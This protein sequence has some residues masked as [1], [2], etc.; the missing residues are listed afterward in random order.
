MAK[1]EGARWDDLDV[2]TDAIFEK[3]AAAAPS[4]TPSGPLASFDLDGS[5]DL[6]ARLKKAAAAPPPFEK[7]APPF[8]KDDPETPQDESKLTAPPFEKKDDGEEKTAEIA[9]AAVMRQT[10]SDICSIL[11]GADVAMD[12]TAGVIGLG[13]LDGHSGESIEEFVLGLSKE[14]FRVPG[15]SLPWDDLPPAGAATNVRR[16]FYRTPEEKSLQA[17]SNLSRV[18]AR[19]TADIDRQMLKDQALAADQASARATADAADRVNKLRAIQSGGVS[20]PDAEKILNE[21]AAAAKRAALAKARSAHGLDK[22][23][24]K[25]G[26]GNTSIDVNKRLFTK[27]APLLLGGAAAGYGLHSLFGKDDDDRRR[28]ITIS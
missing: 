7:K 24:F 8:K 20:R 26:F 15:V 18:N 2:A 17:T 22:N 23:K 9:A 14:A 1:V 13:L 16:F 19:A 10:V 12:K 11:A 6:V 25:F 21:Q 28:G 5:M 3:K 4:S 27:T